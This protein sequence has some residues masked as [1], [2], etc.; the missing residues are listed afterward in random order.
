[1]RRSIRPSTLVND[2]THELREMILGGEIQPGEF[3]PPRKDLAAQFGVGLSTVNEAIQV[4]S[5]V[6]LLASRPGKGTW[7][8]RDALDTLISPAAV[9]ARLGELNA[10]QVCEARAVIEIALTEMAARRATP[11]DIGRIWDALHVMEATIEDS[12]AFVEADLEF[13]LAVARA[14]RNELLEQFYHLSR[15]LLVEV[16]SEM[17]KIPQ[18]GE[19]AIPLQRAIAEAVEQH[20]PRKARRAATAHMDYLGLYLDMQERQE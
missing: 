8:R 4:L 10:R 7:V 11:E 12:T 17:L 19:D 9:K 5:A 2:V 1:M 16:I 15:K 13:H 18:V 6:G 3:L 14:G 20:D